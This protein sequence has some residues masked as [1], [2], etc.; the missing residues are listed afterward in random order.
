MHNGKRE[1]RDWTE[2]RRS[3]MLIKMIMK[4]ARMRNRSGW[5]EGRKRWKK[6]GDRGIEREEKNGGRKANMVRGRYR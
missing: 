3:R 6:R 1:R 5:R 4:Q 2:E